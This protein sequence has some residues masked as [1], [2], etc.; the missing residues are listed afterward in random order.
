MKTKRYILIGLILLSTV[1]T[2]VYIRELKRKFQII[3]EMQDKQFEISKIQLND[4][5]T[6]IVEAFSLKIKFDVY[7]K[8]LRFVNTEKNKHKINTKN[9]LKEMEKYNFLNISNPN[10]GSNELFYLE[11]FGGALGLI[12]LL[13]AAEKLL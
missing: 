10:T 1:I 9:K 6:Y 12:I 11:V 13:Y 5:P 2:I 4:K 8:A 3:D 7:S